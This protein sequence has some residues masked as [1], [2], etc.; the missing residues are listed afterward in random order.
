[1]VKLH[2]SSNSAFKPLSMELDIYVDE[3]KQQQM[4][5]FLK[6][7]D[8]RHYDAFDNK[9]WRYPAKNAPIPDE[10]DES[11][12]YLGEMFGYGYR[13]LS[14]FVVGKIVFKMVWLQLWS[15]QD[16]V[17]SLEKKDY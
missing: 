16:Y 17:E 8:L 4:E 3:L 9:Q 7:D 5:L 2:K 14:K 13:Y 6:D 10:D 15:S 12:A 1:M 11:V